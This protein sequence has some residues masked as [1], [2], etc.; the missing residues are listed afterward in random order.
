M[1]DDERI[2]YLERILAKRRG[3]PGYEANV[4]DI[5]AE[6]ARLKGEA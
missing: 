1:A 2:A 3:A 4:K 5:E 6:L